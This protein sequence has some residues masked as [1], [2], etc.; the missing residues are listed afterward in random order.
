M[1]GLDAFRWTVCISGSEIR[2]N[3]VLVE[4]WRV[5]LSLCALA[6]SRGA[7]GLC[8]LTASVHSLASFFISICS[9][10]FFIFIIIHTGD[11]FAGRR[12]PRTT[13][14]HGVPGVRGPGAWG[15]P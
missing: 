10:L 9:C 7:C 8:S 2:A 12:A 13:D 14:P 4:P 5:Y 6:R 11:S 3:L 15:S 1:D